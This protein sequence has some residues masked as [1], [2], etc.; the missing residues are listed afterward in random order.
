[1]AAGSVRITGITAV[2]IVLKTHVMTHMEEH[3][4]HMPTYNVYMLIH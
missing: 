3:G 1:M 4:M 2:R